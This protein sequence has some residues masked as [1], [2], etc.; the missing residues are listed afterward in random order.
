[1]EQVRSRATLFVWA[2]ISLCVLTV[3]FVL[4]IFALRP[5]G[6]NTGVIATVLGVVTPVI[7][8]LLAVV[9]RRRRAPSG[10]PE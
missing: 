10:E 9:L 8:G 7:G 6:D 1:M 5:K 2:I 4:G 3:G